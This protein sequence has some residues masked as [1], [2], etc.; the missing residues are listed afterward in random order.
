MA[1]QRSTA[2]ASTGNGALQS[3]HTKSDKSRS[4]NRQ[5]IEQLTEKLEVLA[6]WRDDLSLRIA[7]RQN[8]VERVNAW[9][10][11]D[12]LELEVR[13]FCAACDEL[14]GKRRVH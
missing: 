10:G 2:P 8:Y 11:Y 4:A 7:R 12:D 9:A 3:I 1:E 5:E 6:N 14:I 13:D